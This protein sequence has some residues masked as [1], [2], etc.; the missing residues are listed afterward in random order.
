MI[1]SGA[2]FNIEM[3]TGAV[4]TMGVASAFD[5]GKVTMAAHRMKGKRTDPGIGSLFRA[6]L[7]RW[8]LE[9]PRRLVSLLPAAWRLR[10]AEARRRGAMRRLGCPVPYVVAVSPTMHCNYDCGGCYSAGRSTEHEL[11]AAE[12]DTLFGECAGLGVPAI[13]ITGGEPLL[14]PYV[15]GLIERH[16]MLF[17]VLITNGSLVDPGVARRLTASGNVLTLVSIEGNRSDTDARRGAGAYAKAVGALGALR[18]AGALHGFAA[19]VHASNAGYLG[20]DAFIDDMAR[21]GCVTGYFTEYVPCEET[22]RPEW[23][24][25]VEARAA[26][27]RRVLDLRRRRRIV[28]VQFPEDEY[29][30]EN[31]CSA[32][33]RYSLHIGSR[34]EVEPCPFV[35]ISC[36]NVRDGGLER[37][38]RSA[39]LGAIRERP[40]LLRR[41]R[42]A[43][44][45]FEH[46]AEVEELADRLRGGA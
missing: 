18:D 22:P 37:A 6:S 42:L 36:E 1:D 8:A 24:L 20:S 21:L 19:T 4:H 23:L 27:R 7:A 30:S 35:P 28:L 9:R 2:T 41:D 12:L 40:D 5:A 43:C 13:L 16:R 11:S 44:A 33:G 26:F 39:F 25:D 31:I 15:P 38:V 32:A 17:F 29:G 10:R 3:R 45:L 14:L 46:R 34:G